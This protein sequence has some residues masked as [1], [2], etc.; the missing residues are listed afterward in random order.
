[1]ARNRLTWTDANA[2]EDGVR[3][4]RALAAI[5]PENLP[6]PLAEVPVGVQ[7]YE[8][9]NLTAGTTYHYY[10]ASFSGSVVGA[11]VAQQLT[12][13]AELPRLLYGADIV[14]YGAALGATVFSQKIPHCKAGDLLVV[15]GARRVAFTSVTAGWTDAG[16]PPNGSYAQWSFVYWKIADG[17]EP[18]GDFEATTAAAAF[19]VMSAAVFRLDS[20]PIACSTL[21]LQRQ[22]TG[23][24]FPVSAVNGADKAL[25]FCTASR[26]YAPTTG[27]TYVRNFT[28]GIPTL[29]M[30]WDAEHPT[31]RG[32]RLLG[33]VTEAQ[34]GETVTIDAEWSSV[35][36]SSE[37]VSLIWLAIREAT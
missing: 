4:Y 28:R 24:R 31:R 21:A 18:G 32:M 37:S 6:P 16:A 13:V 9:K 22:P 23:Q 20:G 14:T 7:V 17:T 11:G 34:T 33:I 8:D 10:V 12:A 2:G 27:D 19:V 36:S 26:V 29:R 30:E 15:F 3:I 35:A 5:D 25:V 1:M